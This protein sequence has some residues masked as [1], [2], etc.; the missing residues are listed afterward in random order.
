MHAAFFLRRCKGIRVSLTTDQQVPEAVGF[1]V[2]FAGNDYL[3][4]A[5]I[6]SD[7]PG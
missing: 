4:Q 2:K 1:C 6:L 3:W 5:T 7:T